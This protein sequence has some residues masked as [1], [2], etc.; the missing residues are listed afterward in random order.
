[1]KRLILLVLASVFVLGC[2]YYN[3]F[4]N[5]KKA[6]SEAEKIRKRAQKQGSAVPEQAKRLY[7]KAIEN[8]ALVL[9]DHPHSDLVDDALVLIGDAFIAQEDYAK[10]SRKYEEVLVNYPN[11]KWIPYCSFALGQSSLS[12]GDTLRAEEAIHDFLVQYPGSEWA[13]EAHMLLGEIAIQRQQYQAAID[14]YTDYLTSF[15]KHKRRYE[16]Q[17]YIAESYLEIDRHT[18]ALELFE[19]VGKSART[20]ELEFQANYMVGECLRRDQQYE[21]ALQTFEQLAK[22]SSYIEHRP[23]LLLAVASCQRSLNQNELALEN[24]QML[25]ERYEKNRVYD[26]E[27]SQGL[28]D[29]GSIH[30]QQGD[31][32]IAEQFY[33]D[34]RKRSP[35]VFWVSMKAE[36][37]SNDIHQLQ[38]YQ[39]DL[40]EALEALRPPSLP[41]SVQS[42]KEDTTR[43]SI[44]PETIER[45]VS[46][47]FQLAE[48]YLFRFNMIDSALVH[49]RLAEEDAGD[50]ETA[51]KAAYATS[52]I[53]EHILGDTT[54]SRVGYENLL[55]TYGATRYASAAAHSLSIPDPLG[56]SDA[57]MFSRAERLLFTEQQ[58]DSAADSYRQI[59]DQ[60]PDGEYAARALYAI[61][62]I[63]ETY[64]DTP[65]SA[66][67]AYRRLLESYP[68]SDESRLAKLKVRYAE[69]L[70]AGDDDS[71]LADATVAVDPNAVPIHIDDRHGKLV[72]LDG[73]QVIIELRAPL[74]VQIG[75]TGYLFAPNPTDST[76][77]P[78]RAANIRVAE[79]HDTTR[80]GT[81]PGANISL[82]VSPDGE[83]KAFLQTNRAFDILEDLGIWFKVQVEGLEGYV[84][85]EYIQADSAVAPT[86]LC[87]IEERLPPL[88]PDGW[89]GAFF[90]DMAATVDVVVVADTVAVEAA[91][92]TLDDATETAV[93]E[94]AVEAETA[95]DTLAMETVTEPMVETGPKVVVAPSAVSITPPPLR[96][97]D[98]GHGE[99]VEIDGEQVVIRL[100]DTFGIPVGAT[101]Y[102]YTLS[103]KDTTGTPLR[104][105]NIRVAERRAPNAHTGV[106]T[107]GVN[108]R[109]AP[110]STVLR[111]VPPSTK[112]VILGS[113]PG[114]LNVRVDGQLGFVGC[115]YVTP[116]PE[117]YLYQVITRGELNL[118]VEPRGTVLRVL[119]P[120]QTLD[121]LEYDQIWLKVRVDGQEGFVGKAYVLMKGRPYLYQGITTASNLNF[122]AT[123][124]GTVVG[125][126]PQNTAIEVLQVAGEW[127][128]VRAGKQEGFVSKT[129]VRAE[130]ASVSTVLC[131]I[132]ERLQ[133][134]AAGERFGAIF[135]NV[136]DAPDASSNED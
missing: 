27:V 108:L 71:A 40:I 86:V 83:F 46:V 74:P 5:A 59:V 109:S 115:A 100:K 69:E 72:T 54:S 13:P 105:A 41:D 117:W 16:A 128:K 135:D 24:L 28:F 131:Q 118:R 43:F 96:Y 80:K 63:A 81:N 34:A 50:S 98:I 130:P 56:L 99:V 58:P 136:E 60:F 101:G 92:D 22:R 9:R 48:T 57:D 12:A 90:D 18:E 67:S 23:K 53:M 133:P 125:S 1:M 106:T 97:S 26:A 102:L 68:K 14:E 44:D 116:S 4:Y 7:E 77:S 20:R 82:Y 73:D 111:T 32:E 134:L 49:Y 51:A 33:L 123:P 103:A 30:E 107:H 93:D 61:G 38:Q 2:P 124:E 55:E 8:S 36:E 94:V 129:Y 45:V 29:I 42:D 110:D 121:V 91:A 66:L 76:L 88:V 112:V 113:R 17:F 120:D 114:W 65:D 21:K 122:R 25:T 70:L 35:R 19:K 37:K 39:Q 89:F 15:P 6:F 87:E 31:L 11:S 47:R 75:D 85:S 10:A 132:E 84:K 95:V 126:L 127:L 52:W 3:T 104:V 64:Q 78:L 62:W 119:P 79:V